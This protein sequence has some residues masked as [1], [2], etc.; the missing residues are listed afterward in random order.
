M[1]I[2]AQLYTA[3]ET[4]WEDSA[5]SQAIFITNADIAAIDGETGSGYTGIFM[6]RYGH[7]VMHLPIT[8]IIMFSL[9]FFI[10][11]RIYIITAIRVFWDSS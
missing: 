4:D 10:I 9:T 3:I 2:P 11:I 8:G 7:F 1:S 6:K 5:L